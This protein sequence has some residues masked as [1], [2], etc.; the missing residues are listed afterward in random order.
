MMIRKKIG[1]F[2]N[3]R[4]PVLSFEE[5]KRRYSN[6]VWIATVNS[7][8][9]DAPRKRLNNK[10]R[11]NGLLSASSGFHPVRY[12]YLLEEAG[13]LKAITAEPDESPDRFHACAL[14]RMVIL[15][16][17]ANSGCVYFDNLVDGHPDLLN[18][19]LLGHYIPLQEVYQKRLRF[20][21]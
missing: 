11:E 20:L 8:T 7:D 16:H 17:M 4:I 6:A 2:Y 15:N 14:R 3:D 18:I 19:V 12:L 5:S 9:V 1:R 13:I 10:L 21:R